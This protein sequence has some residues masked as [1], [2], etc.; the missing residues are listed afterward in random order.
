MREKLTPTRLAKLY[1]GLALYGLGMALQI[2]SALGGSPWDVFHQGLA[3]HFGLSVGTWVIIV[4]AVVMLAWIPLRQRPGLGTISN[5]LFL[6]LFAD[7]FLWLLPG[8]EHVVPRSAYLLAGVFLVALATVLYIG[9]GLGPG[10]RDGIMTGLVRLGLSIRLA[11]T[12]I[13]VSVLAIGWILGGTA[14]VG[15]LLFAL[16]IGPLTQILS[17][18]FPLEAAP[19]RPVPLPAD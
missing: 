16:A 3:V 12:L 17:R 14:G 18:W 5:V 2:E 11:R 13:E 7:L 1:G 10:P 9:A 6:G 15:T 19:P 4:G 8:P